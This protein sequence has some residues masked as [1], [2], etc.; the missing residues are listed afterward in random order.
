[1]SYELVPLLNDSGEYVFE[2]VATSDL[3]SVSSSDSSNSV[4][5][6]YSKNELIIPDAPDIETDTET[7][8]DYT[9][10]ADGYLTYRPLEED[11]K[12]V[13]YLYSNSTGLRN[14]DLKTET[15]NLNN[16]KYITKKEIYAVRL[17]YT[18]DGK[19]YLVDDLKF[20]NPQ[21]FGNLSIYIMNG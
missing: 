10:S 8:I 14:F 16:A 1:V 4:T 18:L 12:Y 5:F 9:I 2:V 6:E 3:L 19:T 20:Y 15:V 13:L 7:N 21:K 17:G 11:C